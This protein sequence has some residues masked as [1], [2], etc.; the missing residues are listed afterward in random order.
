MHIT[1]ITNVDSAIDKHNATTVSFNTNLLGEIPGKGQFIFYLTGNGGNF[2]VKGHISGF[3]ALELNKVAVP[4]ALMRVNTGTV[5]GID[6]N[7]KGNDSG[8]K[9]DFVMNYDNLKVDVLSK[10]KIPGKLRRRV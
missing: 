5:N 4:M 2:A 6:F 1:N 9:G 10:I 3:D 8:A 7:F